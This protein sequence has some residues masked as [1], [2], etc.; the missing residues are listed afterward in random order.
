VIGESQ[1]VVH[2]AHDPDSIRHPLDAD[3]LASEGKA[4]VDLSLAEAEATATGHGCLAVVE[5][6]SEWSETTVGSP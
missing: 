1:V 6:I 3:V 2:E 4:Q 5:R